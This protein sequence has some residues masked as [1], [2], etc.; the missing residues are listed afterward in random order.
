MIINMIFIITFDIVHM[1]MNM[2]FIITSDIV[3]K[4]DRILLGLRIFQLIRVSHYRHW[5]LRSWLIN[6]LTKIKDT[7]TIGCHQEVR[8]MKLSYP[9]K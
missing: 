8:T 3:H 1:I 7:P 9:L 5:I 2:I 6:D 4:S